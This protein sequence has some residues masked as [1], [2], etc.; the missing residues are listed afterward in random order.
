MLHTD[1]GFT[2][3]TSERKKHCVLSHN[4]G[5]HHEK[6]LG[7]IVPKD[8]NEV[9]RKFWLSILRREWKA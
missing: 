1:Y 2:D 6:Y 5:K 8:I 3:Q 9:K 7:K 4:S